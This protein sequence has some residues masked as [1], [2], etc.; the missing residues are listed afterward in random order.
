[1]IG[2]VRSRFL[3]RRD[4]VKVNFRQRLRTNITELSYAVTKKRGTERTL[5]KATKTYHYLNDLSNRSTNVR[6]SFDFD[7]AVSSHNFTQRDG[8]LYFYLIFTPGPVY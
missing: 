7:G 5:T 3:N 4:D 6:V 1:M 2:N 8:G